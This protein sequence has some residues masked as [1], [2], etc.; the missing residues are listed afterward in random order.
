[1]NTD[2]KE[3]NKLVSI[4]VI[5]V[6][7][8]LKADKKQ[9]LIWG[10]VAT[11]FGVVVAIT[12]PKTYKSSVLLAPEETSSGFSGNLSSLASMVGMDVKLGESGDAIYPELY[13]D[14]VSSVDFLT[15]MF[16]VKVKTQDGSV[17]CDYYTYLKKHT[18]LGM[19]DYPLAL[20]S[21]VV[22]KLTTDKKQQKKAGK[23]PLNPFWLTKEEDGVCKNINKNINCSVDKKTSV[24]SIS[25]EDQDPLVA[26]TVADSM[27]AHLQN[28]ITIYR[29][30]KA[31]NDLNFM[32]NIYKEAHA[33]YV[34]ARQAY[35]AY[36]D[37][38]QDVLLQS[39]KLKEEDL[40]N[41]MQLKYNIYQQVV[42]Q[43]QL[44]KVKVQDN[45]SR[46]VCS[47]E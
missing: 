22:D 17:Q 7:N 42:E 46:G 20:V 25:V 24:I 1:M 30:Q 43:L 5:D 13:P 14:L 34:Q 16:P 23:S 41:E 2:K 32:Q 21:N 15:G 38:N 11:V 26:A 10:G 47:S 27:R 8:L 37:A 3:N 39:Y 33:Q 44:A 35:A 40:E 28:A 12:T 36:A 4:S 45:S 6:I 29:T 31:R 18:K 9:L 19:L